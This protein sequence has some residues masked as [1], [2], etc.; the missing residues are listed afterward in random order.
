MQRIESPA[1]GF[2]FTTAFCRD[3]RAN[4]CPQIAVNVTGTVAVRDSAR[5]DQVVTFTVEDW[6]GFIAEQAE[7]MGLLA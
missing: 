3:P 7:S 1:D 4:N 5:P 6:Q 2:D